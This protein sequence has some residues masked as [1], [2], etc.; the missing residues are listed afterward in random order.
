MQNNHVILDQ[1]KV[2]LY[3]KQA[4]RCS[5]CYI[6]KPAY[7]LGKIVIRKVEATDVLLDC[8]PQSLRLYRFPY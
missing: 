6:L 7:K 2:M 5:K 8:H 4:N 3:K 1:G